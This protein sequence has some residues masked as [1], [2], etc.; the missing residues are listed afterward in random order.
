MQV[1]KNYYNYKK[2]MGLFAT[3]Q[4]LTD[5]VEQEQ[6]HDAYEDAKIA[7]EIFDIFKDRINKDQS[8]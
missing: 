3:Y 6:A 1:M 7:K 2:E 4:E 8:L 5:G